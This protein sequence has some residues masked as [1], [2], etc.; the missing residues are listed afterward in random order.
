MKYHRLR[1]REAATSQASIV[2]RQPLAPNQP[3]QQNQPQV[4]INSVA[5]FAEYHK[6][7]KRPIASETEWRAIVNDREPF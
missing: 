4:V 1:A 2:N 3:N 6:F 5:S 7:P